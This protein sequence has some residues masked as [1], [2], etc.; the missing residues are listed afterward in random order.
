MPKK[1]EI[2]LYS[3]KE[4]SKKAQRKAI[5]RLVKDG[6]GEVEVQDLTISFQERLKELGL[7]HENIQWS[8]GYSQGDGVSFYGAV[9]V[10]A[11]L[12]ATEL[13][14]LPEA[15]GAG[16]SVRKRWALRRQDRDLLEKAR[17]DVRIEQVGRYTHSGSMIVEYELYEIDSDDEK[18]R[19]RIEKAVENLVEEIRAVIVKVSRELEKEGYAE[20]EYRR[21]DEAIMD[22]AEA[23]ELLFFENGTL[24][25]GP[26]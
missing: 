1:K 19:G 12:Q 25:Q 4:L 5:D 16:I 15:P 22:D 13:A 18:E 2:I 26:D 11:Y 6:W 10:E 8:L 17:F 20:I 7:P 9:D 24:Y 23:N 21:S 3:I 14:R